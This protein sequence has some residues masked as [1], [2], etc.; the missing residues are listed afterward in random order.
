MTQQWPDQVV[1][2][3]V[4]CDLVCWAGGE[5][6]DP[7]AHGLNPGEWCTALN[8]GWRAHYRVGERLFIDELLL[9]HETPGFTAKQHDRMRGPPIN[10]VHA[11]A[12]PRGGGNSHYLGLA[13]PIA[14]GG[15][16]LIGDGDAI[17]R[18]QRG[19]PPAWAYLRLRELVF[20]DG[21][22]IEAVDHSAIAAG[23]R[24]R[25][26]QCGDADRVLGYP[27]GQQWREAFCYDYGF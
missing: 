20:V 24:D 17:E 11:Q 19:S 12:Y 26:R 8:R 22:L 6:F 14:F 21:A 4:S 18:F 15:G 3:G 23:L 5:L 9:H 10:G 16:L 27:A 2:E 7:R 13:L 25:E 1:F